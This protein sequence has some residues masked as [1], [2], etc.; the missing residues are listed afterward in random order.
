MLQEQNRR[1]RDKTPFRA[2]ILAG[3]G[4][5]RAKKNAP[6]RQRNVVVTTSGACQR[7]SLLVLPP[8]GAAADETTRSGSRGVRQESLRHRSAGQRGGPP[9]M[10]RCATTARTRPFERSPRRGNSPG[11]PGNASAAPT[12]GASPPSGHR[13][14]CDKQW[15]RPPAK[16]QLP[17]PLALRNLWQYENYTLPVRR[18]DTRIVGFEQE[19]KA[20]AV[21]WSRRIETNSK[22]LSTGSR[23]RP[24]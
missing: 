19:I 15:A 10:T 3:G 20:G 18:D 16:G 7:H 5:W 17:S 9:D 11:V 21:G 23:I 13:P 1:F 8:R 6:N 4:G 2:R 12:I 24:M 22:M 14:W